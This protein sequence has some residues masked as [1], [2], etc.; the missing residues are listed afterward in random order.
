[1][2]AGKTSREIARLR[3]RWLS[4]LLLPYDQDR[5]I[6]RLQNLALLRFQARLVVQRRHG[7]LVQ[8]DVTRA[9]TANVRR[10]H[11]RVG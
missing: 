10:Y 6:V 2:S 9:A 4:F 1:M 3:Q 8:V 11:R 7:E 5:R